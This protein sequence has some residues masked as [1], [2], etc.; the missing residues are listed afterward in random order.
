MENVFIYFLKASALIAVYFTAY[1]FLLRKETFFNTNRWFLLAG[2]FTSAILPLFF[3]KKT[4]WVEKQKVSI[5]DLIQYS[6][7]Q[8]IPKTESFTIDWNQILIAFYV[9]ISAFLLIKVITNLVSLVKLLHNKEVI[10]K[11]KF[12]LVDLNE[13]IAPFSFF[14]Y[15]VFN[16]DY[17][18]NE[19]LRSILLHEKVHSE[20]KHS[21]DVMIAK[22]FCIVFWFNPFMWL[23]KKAI[24][25]NLE[26]IADQK[27]CLQ[28]EDKKTYQKALL[29]VV[30]H[31]NCLSI[32]NHFYQSLIK[33]RIVMLNK[34]QSHKRNSWKYTVVIP[35]LVAFF[36]LFQIKVIAQERESKIVEKQVDKK[37]VSIVID[38][39]S[40][41]NDIKKD[42]DM[43]KKEHNVNLKVS[44][45][46]RNSQG[47]ITGIKVEYKDN[48]GNN[49]S[50]QS[51]SDT[52]IEPIHF[53][54]ESSNDGRN[55]IGFGKPRME[56]KRSHGMKRLAELNKDF[57]E[58]E[59]ERK[60]EKEVEEGLN[61]SFAWSFS[62][63]DSK[64][65][66]SIERKI[67]IRKDGKN[68]KPE[69]IINGEKLDIPLADLEKMDKDFDGKFEFKSGDNGPFIFKFN[70]EEIMHFSP[71][72]IERIKE[73]AMESSKAM[74]ISKIH[75]KKMKE[76]M[77]KMRPDMERM[78]E[79]MQYDKEERNIEM[80][81][82]R[83]EMQ[84]AREEML[85]AKEEMKKAREEMEK[86]KS[87]MKT[88]KA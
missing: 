83:E 70:D 72:D 43:L 34:N 77:E 57:D 24:I 27:A 82:A 68:G 25:Q 7:A 53:Y 62:D 5:D 74:E 85:K 54:K 80:Q 26:Y 6:K 28:I 56:L 71:E 35:V 55:R 19:E 15:I 46:K 81:K 32:T 66:K 79:K 45:I 14:N 13:D 20:E 84:K 36:I 21:L 61:K 69:V 86:A 49:G 87:E 4:I 60:I 78:R 9:V 50:M 18:T 11:D 88:R 29:K 67:V 3:I 41:D 48:D 51:Q 42:A 75:M 10:K 22:I 23:Y 44:K 63:D 1:Y 73:D 40:S 37:V 59:L 33:K 16:S 64:D 30:S 17:Y 8:I 65:G 38:K 39:N 2:L 76:H 52:P 31:Q 47:E 58:D 12:S